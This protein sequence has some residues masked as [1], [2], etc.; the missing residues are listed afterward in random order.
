MRPSYRPVIP[1]PPPPYRPQVFAPL[2][3]VAGRCAALGI[4][5]V[6]ARATK[7]DPARRMVTAGHAV[8][9]MVR[10]GLG[11]LHSPDEGAADRGLSLAGGPSS[12]RGVAHR[13]GRLHAA[14]AA[15]PAHRAHAVNACTTLCRTACACACASVD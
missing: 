5:A 12:S 2:G 3:L 9:A 1:P 13:W 15:G 4:P 8:T 11:V 10:T 7:P 14:L 6:I